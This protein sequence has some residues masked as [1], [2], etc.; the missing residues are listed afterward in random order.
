ML[1]TYIYTYIH[2]YIHTQTQKL[3][4]AGGNLD[5]DKVRLTNHPLN[6]FPILNLFSLLP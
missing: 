1:H 2:T 3:M 6:P 5:T 4:T